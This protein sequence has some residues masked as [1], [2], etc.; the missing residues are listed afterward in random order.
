M[1]CEKKYGLDM[2]RIRHLYILYLCGGVWKE[3]GGRSVEILL[4][5]LKYKLR[6]E[7]HLTLQVTTRRGLIWFLGECH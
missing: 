3:I 6:G 1:L 2:G 5:Y 4:L 7:Y